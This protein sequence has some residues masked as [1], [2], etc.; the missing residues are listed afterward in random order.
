MLKSEKQEA[1]SSKREV[2][3]MEREV[4]SWEKTISLRCS[5]ISS[6]GRSL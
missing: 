4:M 3:R 2:I 5:P 1:V 6:G